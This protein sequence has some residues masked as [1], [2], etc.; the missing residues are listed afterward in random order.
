M[1]PIARSTCRI[2][3]GRT[4]LSFSAFAS[5]YARNRLD[6]FGEDTVGNA[7]GPWHQLASVHRIFRIEYEGLGS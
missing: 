5:R 6:R 4:R 2:A 3:V 7:N 1:T